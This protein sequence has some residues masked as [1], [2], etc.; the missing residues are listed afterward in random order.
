MSEEKQPVLYV[1]SSADYGY[2]AQLCDIALKSKGLEALSI[3]NATTNAIETK[4][5]N[6]EA[7]SKHGLGIF[8]NPTHIFKQKLEEQAIAIKKAE[9]LRLLAEQEAKEEEADKPNNEAKE[10]PLKKRSR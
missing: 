6:I 3:V 8:L 9:E 2:V 5:I 1:I 10:T 7:I 4:S